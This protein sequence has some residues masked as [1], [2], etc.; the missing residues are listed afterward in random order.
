[1]N[2]LD[3]LE[4]GWSL[5]PGQQV[6][7]D[8]VGRGPLIGNVVA[9]AV[10]LPAECDLPLT[11]S[12]KL[13]PEQREA[14]YSLIIEQALD[15]AIAEVE[16]K[17]I[18]EMNILQA[19]LYAMRQAVETLIHPYQQVLVDGNRCPQLDGDCYPVVK[20]DAKVA[21]ISAASILA[22]VHRDRQMMELDTLYPQYGFAK[23]KGYPTREHLAAIEKYGLIDGYRYSFKPIAQMSAKSAKKY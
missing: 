9:A 7:V 6:G 21:E 17:L 19:T 8:E 1:M 16:P 18:D 15:Y 13:K 10:I 22:K 12:K 20:G 3:W 2:Q 5:M 14:L 4:Q 23:H 11:D